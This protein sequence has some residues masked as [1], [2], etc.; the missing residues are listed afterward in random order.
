MINSSQRKHFVFFAPVIFS[1]LKN[2]YTIHQRE[3]SLS[4]SQWRYLV[5]KSGKHIHAWLQIAPGTPLMGFLSRMQNN[6]GFQ[7]T[8][9]LQPSRLKIF[10]KEKKN[11]KCCAGEN[12]NGKGK[13]LLMVTCQGIVCLMKPHEET[14]I[15]GRD[16]KHWP[17][18]GETQDFGLTWYGNYYFFV[19]LC[20]VF[21]SIGDYRLYEQLEQAC[22][23][24]L[25]GSM[26]TFSS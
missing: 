9:H 22:S 12:Q 21:W 11:I 3:K 10:L 23:S 19:Y 16:L 25:G 20:V 14:F 1:S 6:C 24:G 17:L 8:E 4:L 18:P 15:T 13:E 7:F 5:Q 2:R 26:Q